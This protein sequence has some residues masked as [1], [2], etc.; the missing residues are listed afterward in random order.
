M[1]IQRASLIVGRLF[2]N[3]PAS[4]PPGLPTT[5]ETIRCPVSLNYETFNEPSLIRT[6]AAVER[7]VS[8]F[9]TNKRRRWLT[10]SGNSGTGK[11]FLAL[12]VWRWFMRQGRRPRSV[13]DGRVIGGG[14][15]FYKWRDLAQ[16]CF[17]L[18]YS[19]LSDAAEADTWLLV[20]DDIASVR[21]PSGNLAEQLWRLLDSRLN[22]WALFTSNKDL[23]QFAKLDP[24]G[25]TGVRIASR[26]VRD[27]NEVV[28]V[29]AMDY[30]LR[31]QA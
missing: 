31:A 30:A 24:D 21:D 27:G 4:T 3:Q 23:A 1:A 9:D 25:G 20:V 28:E 11:T 29:E 14:G 16:R 5:S 2:A 19:W 13:V 22:T 26:L 18:D 10:L 8:D 7:W 6:K 17:D 15:S 12:Q